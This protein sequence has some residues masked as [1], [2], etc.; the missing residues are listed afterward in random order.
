MADPEYSRMMELLLSRYPLY[1]WATFLRFG[2]RETP[3]GLL[4]TLAALD[5]P[6]PGEID[7]SV[8][9][10]AIGEPYTLRIALGAEQHRLAVGI[11]H[12]HPEE[13]APEPSIVDDDMD[14]YYSDYF[15]GFAVDRPY[16]SLIVSRLGDEIVFSGRVFWKGA[17]HVVSKFLVERTRVRTYR[18]RSTQLPIGER[19]KRLAAAFGS[20]AANDLR[21]AV[22][23]VVGA[24]GT[25]SAVIE[26]LARAGVGHL[27]LIDPDHIE[28][29]N[30]ERL[31]GGFRE[32]VAA[33]KWKVD[34]AE[35]H[36][37]QIDSQIRVTTCRGSLPQPE[38]VDLLVTANLV[39]GCTDQQHSRL[40]LGELAYRY[41]VPVMDCGVALEGSNGKITGH[42]IQLANF[43]AAGPCALCRR[44]IDPRRVGQ[45]LMSDEER[46]S[47]RRAA[48]EAEQRGDMADNY[49]MGMPQ[50]NTVG[51]MTTTAGSM[52]AGYAIGYLTHRFGPAYTQL[53]LNLFSEPVNMVDWVDHPQADCVCRQVRGWADQAKAEAVITP[54]AHWP[55]PAI[56]S[57]VPGEAGVT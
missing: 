46:A 36:V 44:M 8:G 22:V 32:D 52:L 47:R 18:Q 40:A 55:A 19:V 9:H 14:G 42:T 37:H 54:P 28:E 13:C 57:R 25:G 50:L 38:I 23:G 53:Q 35:R 26:V 39:L 29:S 43:F 7:D 51:Y 11:I 16:V 48:E 24:G 15:I 41:L 6:L 5:E 1:E 33:R 34:V 20:D 49:W 2:W 56:S 4:L 27:I 31:H 10:V 30:L 12:S 17:W 45:E 21:H 3:D